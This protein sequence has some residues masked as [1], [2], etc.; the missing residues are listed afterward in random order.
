MIPDATDLSH[1]GVI[2]LIHIKISDLL[3]PFHPPFL[4]LH[5]FIPHYAPPFHPIYLF[6]S[7][8]RPP[9]PLH[10]YL[11]LCGL[12]LIGEPS[13]RK[14]H[15][16]LNITQ[17]AFQRLQQLQQTWRDST[18]SCS[19]QH[20]QQDEPLPRSG[21]AH[22]GQSKA[23]GRPLRVLKM[24]GRSIWEAAFSACLTLRLHS[25]NV[26]EKHFCYTIYAALFGCLFISRL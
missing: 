7:V 11:G 9:D 17:R 26:G 21:A 15:P 22:S 19:R 12:S 5:S 8:S 2:A 16:A 10:A 1:A 25:C 24:F 13:L 4:S 3:S 6:L 23:T 18:G 14:V 20:W